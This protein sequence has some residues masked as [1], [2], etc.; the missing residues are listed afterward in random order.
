MAGPAAAPAPRPVG[1]AAQ[2][3]ALPA[4]AKV[5]IGVALVA[6]I[7]A[8]YYFA[9]HSPLADDI[10]GA[11]SRGTEL[12]DDR[13][14]AQARQREYLELR[15]ELTAREGLD[16]AN[17]RV[18]PED[19]EMA[20]FLADLTRLAELSGLQMQLV[21]PQPEEEDTH[22]TRLPVSLHVAGRYHQLTRFFYNVSRL[23]RA[24]SMENLVMREPIVSGEDVLLTVEVMA[25]TYRRPTPADPTAGTTPG[26]SS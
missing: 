22:Y 5:G 11:R 12:E 2:F 8:I 20:A 1:A 17:L 6:V 18:L 14:A 24:I 7:C 15:E 21:E 26:G 19:A 13:I 23:E 25:T 10:D 16:R 4:P 3:V 9:L